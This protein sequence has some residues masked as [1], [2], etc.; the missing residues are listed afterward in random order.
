MSVRHGS[1][2]VLI[3]AWALLQLGAA[4]TLALVDGATALSHSALA[5]GHIEEHSSDSCQP[6]HS[7]DCALCQSLSSHVANTPSTEALEWPVVRRTRST[8]QPR[9]CGPA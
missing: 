7:A 2:R 1:T 4:P 5:V 3:A 9:A 6:P 8:E